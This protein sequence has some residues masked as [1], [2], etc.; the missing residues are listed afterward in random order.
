M[1]TPQKRLRAVLKK[2]EILEHNLGSLIMWESFS[3]HIIGDPSGAGG[4]SGG[5]FSKGNIAPVVI[6][7]AA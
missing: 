2:M 7:L 6:G 4:G 5:I 1:I 3:S